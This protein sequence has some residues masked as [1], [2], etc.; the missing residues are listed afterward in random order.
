MGEAAPWKKKLF[1]TAVDTE[2]GAILLSDLART[3]E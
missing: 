3:L 2:P 1:L